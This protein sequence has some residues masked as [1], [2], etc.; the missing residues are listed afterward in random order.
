MHCIGLKYDTKC[1]LKGVECAQL[2][3]LILQD[4]KIQQIIASRT[5]KCISHP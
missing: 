2:A 4:P 3:A 1:I 5:Q